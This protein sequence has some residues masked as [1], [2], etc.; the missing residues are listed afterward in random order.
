MTD[1]PALV[2]QHNS[3]AACLWAVG[4]GRVLAVEEIIVS[5]HVLTKTDKSRKSLSPQQLWTQLLLSS[6]AELLGQICGY[7]QA[8]HLHLQGE[9]LMSAKI[10]TLQ[11][12]EATNEHEF[13][14]PWA[15]LEEFAHSH[16]RSQ[17]CEEEE[18]EEE[19]ACRAY[20]VG[21]SGTPN[22]KEPA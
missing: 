9:H 12:R 11:H 3:L 19:D 13:P 8:G 5:S 14:Q 4:A 16:S 20:P 1:K 15:R 2:P 22:P 21:E 17:A 18:E 7:C 10:S 6:A